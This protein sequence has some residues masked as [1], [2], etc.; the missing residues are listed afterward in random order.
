MRVSAFLVVAFVSV[1]ATLS[2]LSAAEPTGTALPGLEPFD[3]VIPA[4]ME[5]WSI[6][7]ASL[8]VARYG[9]VLL[10]RGYGLADRDRGVAVQP[11][12]LF[13][14]GSLAKPIT[15]V[16]ILQLV[17]EGRLR[18]DDKILPL[19]GDLGP[20]ASAITDPRVYDI[21]VRNLLQHTGGF[22]RDKSGDPL[23][24]PRLAAVAARQ[25]GPRPPA[26]DMILRDSLETRLDFAPGTRFAYS[27]V[28]YC[29]LGRII[30][31]VSGM[32]YA[33]F[34]RSR[35]L[36]PSGARGIQLG[37][38]LTAA[39]GEV[40]YY[41]FP[42][43][44]RVAPAPGLGRSPVPAPYGSYSLEAMDSLGQ[45][46]GSTVDYL[47]F[48][49]T[50]DGQRR[51]AL[52]QEATVHEMRARPD[53][54]GAGSSPVFYALGIEVRHVAGGDNWWHDGSQPGVVTFAVRTAEGFA[55]V[56]AF[57][58]R[59]RDQTGFVRDLDGALWK[60][61][62]QVVHWPAGDLFDQFH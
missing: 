54:P 60:A 48:F 3:A 1:A 31:R 20:P 33:D 16:A 50:I 61:A 43:A 44:P 15:A 24:M 8:A 30:Q 7:G 9:R 5:K 46:I 4:L 34:V 14:L 47:R 13:R 59:P 21:T 26:C 37:H 40:V 36:L 51:P 38:T 22:D 23:F 2:P 55:W 11:T 49:M 39:E 17:E 52:L 41:D 18:L 45:W 6:P 10:A 12:S 57:N 53:I 19:L 62:G 32:T 25:P 35:I 27:N 28:G 56:A 58:S 29:I 42:G